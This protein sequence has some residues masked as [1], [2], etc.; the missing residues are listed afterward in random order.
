MNIEHWEDTEFQQNRLG[1]AIGTWCILCIASQKRLDPSL[2]LEDCQAKLAD[3]EYKSE[4]IRARKAISEELEANEKRTLPVFVPSLQVGQ[5]TRYG[6]QIYTKGALISDGDIYLATG[7][8]GA[9][10]GLTP[11]SVEL[12]APGVWNAFYV[13]SLDGIPDDIK[14]RTK[15]IK[16]FHEVGCVKDS[17]SVTPATQ[18]SAMQGDTCFH[19][20]AQQYKILRP[21]QMSQQLKTIEELKELAGFIDAEVSNRLEADASDN[22]LSLQEIVDRTTP[23]ESA[24]SGASKA[25]AGLSIE[26]T[27]AAIPKRTSKRKAAPKSILPPPSAVQAALCDDPTAEPKPESASSK[28][29]VQRDNELANMD[30][31]MRRVAELHRSSKSTASAKSLAHLVPEKFMEP[32]SDHSRGHSL[33]AAT[34]HKTLVYVMRFIPV[35]EARR[36]LE[37]LRESH[38]EIPEVFSLQ[39]RLTLCETLR[40]LTDAPKLYSMSEFQPMVAAVKPFWGTMPWHLKNKITWSRSHVDLDA[41]VEQKF[42]PE[43]E[44]P[45]DLYT[46]TLE[47]IKKLTTRHFPSL[48]WAEWDGEDPDFGDVLGETFRSLEDSV[49]QVAEGTEGKDAEKAVQLMHEAAQICKEAMEEKWG[50]IRLESGGS[51]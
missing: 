17:F 20:A 51:L 47:A 9:G 39:R 31:E 21:E 7:K 4:F 28:K 43:P 40:T 37:S 26:S 3:P 45:E 2:T 12:I 1:A 33:V 38:G 29:Q 22:A 44:T 27:A 50:W 34:C 30:E 15:R 46:V 6:H 35:T 16:I 41:I 18:L 5:Q 11:W 48:S 19:H 24:A 36:I 13:V 10:L 25:L 23:V 32:G 49:L 42:S 8:T 14:S